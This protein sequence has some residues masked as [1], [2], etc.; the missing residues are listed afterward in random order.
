MADKVQLLDQRATRINALVN[1]LRDQR[2]LLS[3]ILTA[4]RQVST[5]AY[6]MCDRYATKSDFIHV[7]ILR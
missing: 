7:Y 2:T 3:R 5:L 1:A 4:M 6:C